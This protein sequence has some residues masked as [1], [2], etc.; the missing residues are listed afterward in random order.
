M[1]S[2]SV[3][4]AY[5]S[6]KPIK[7]VTVLFGIKN[8]TDHNPPYTNASQ[9]NFGGRLQ[10]ARRRSDAAQLLRQC[11]GRPLLNPFR[12]VDLKAPPRAG[13]LCLQSRRSCRDPLSKNAT[14][15]RGAPGGSA[16]LYPVTRAF[17]KQLL[18]LYDKPPIYYPL[19]TLMLAA[20][21]RPAG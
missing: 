16:R 14:S 2:Y 21:R 5:F 8:L 7:Q 13:L 20:I 6:V 3:F 4:D 9:G 12:K 17:S 19:A 18:P 1:G 15:R 11:E 10:C